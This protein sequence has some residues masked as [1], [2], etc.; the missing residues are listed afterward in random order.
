MRLLV[1]GGVAAGMSAAAQARRIDPTLE[2]VVLEKT[3]TV[4][5]GA[6]GLPYFVEGKLGNAAD[7]IVQ[8][9]VVFRD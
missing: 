9:A 2:I 5:Y 1:I 8:P 4:S 7:L 6:C 3:D